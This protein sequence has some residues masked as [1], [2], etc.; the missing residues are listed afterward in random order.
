MDNNRYNTSDVKKMCEGKL[1]ISF[2]SGK[3]FNG[4][5]EIKGKRFA[6]ITISMGRK[7]IPPK[8]YKSY[9]EQLKISVDDFDDLMSCCKVY[10]DYVA[11]VS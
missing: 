8:T 2:R 5:F 11:C 4:W 3:E 6:R 10:A 1:S 9:A 7:P